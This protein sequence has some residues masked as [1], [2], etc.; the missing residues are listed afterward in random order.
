MDAV[1]L[2]HGIRGRDL[3]ASCSKQE[4]RRQLMMWGYTWTA[5]SPDG[6]FFLGIAY[7]P[8]A[9]ESNDP[10]FKLPAFDRLF[11]RQRAL[12]DG[13]ER[14]AVMREAKNLLVAYMP[15]QGARARRR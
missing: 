6:G 2:K 7:G 14:E 4:P 12:P 13:P 11:E 3:A 9:G 5:G 10:R 8:N 1:G 15:L